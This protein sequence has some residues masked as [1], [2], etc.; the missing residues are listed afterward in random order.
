M[1]DSRI[2]PHSEPWN[3]VFQG[4]WI[5]IPGAECTLPSVAT[6]KAW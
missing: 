5:V 6:V 2:D 3:A 1:D 4:S